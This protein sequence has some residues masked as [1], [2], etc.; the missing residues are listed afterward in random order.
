MEKYMTE[1]NKKGP[2]KITREQAKFFRPTERELLHCQ[3]KA[4]ELCHQVSQRSLEVLPRNPA[5]PTRPLVAVAEAARKEMCLIRRAC[6][7]S[8]HLTPKERET[9][10][11]SRALFE[12]E[13]FLGIEGR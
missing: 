1:T 4:G 11:C 8:D 13:D 10:P 12:I 5:I 7:V 9:L 2:V 6:P 3:A